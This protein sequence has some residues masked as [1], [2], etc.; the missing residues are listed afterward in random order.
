M[1]AV[2]ETTIEIKDRVKAVAAD[3]GCS[4]KQLTTY[5]VQH[6][7]EKFE[8]GELSVKGSKLEVIKQEG[9]N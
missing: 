7:I 8:S 2:L 3:Q 6:G 9:G 4:A 1:K 5:I